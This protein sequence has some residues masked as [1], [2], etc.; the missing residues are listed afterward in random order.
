MFVSKL[1]ADAFDRHLARLFK[2]PY[3]IHRT[4]CRGFKEKPRLLY[5]HDVTIE[6]FETLVYSEFQPDWSSLERPGLTAVVKEIHPVFSKNSVLYFK[7]RANPCRDS[8]GKREGIVTLEGQKQWLLRK[9]ETGGF[10]FRLEKHNFEF[11]RFRKGNQSVTHIAADFA[12]TLQVTNAEQFG[13]AFRN[14]MGRAKYAGFG[15]LCVLPR[16]F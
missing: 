12:G 1:V 5:R 16:R 13:E 10:K 9:A 15:M 6:G 7:L 4:L 8:D 11:L 3:E 14:G 2:T